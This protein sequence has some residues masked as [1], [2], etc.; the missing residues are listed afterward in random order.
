[1][2]VRREYPSELSVFKGKSLY[3]WQVNYSANVLGIGVADFLEI[4]PREIF[5][6][7]KCGLIFINITQILGTWRFRL[8]VELRVGSTGT[9]R[10]LILNQ[11]S[12]SGR[13]TTGQINVGWNGYSG[14]NALL[15]EKIELA[16]ECTAL[17]LGEGSI[18]FDA[19]VV[20]YN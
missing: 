4:E 14:V 13:T 6:L 5:P 1:M 3:Q 7:Y 2:A 12:V 9:H 11:M 8:Y 15:A 10:H 17:S 19:D 16:V 18:G 20:F